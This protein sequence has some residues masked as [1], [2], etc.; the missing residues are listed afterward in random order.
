MDTTGAAVQQLTQDG[1]EARYPVWSPD[2]RW[3]AW[4][5]W[6]GTTAELWL[7]RSDGTEARKIADGLWP[8][9]APDSRRIAYTAAETWNGTY[10][11]FSIDTSTGEIRQLT[12]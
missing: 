1:F 12:R 10:R 6:H 9:W 7:M 11:L 2:G 5:S 3:I 8:V 4:G